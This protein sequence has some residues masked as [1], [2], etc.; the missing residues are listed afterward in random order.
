MDPAPA[1]AQSAPTES[2]W[3]E[4]PFLGLRAF[5]EADHARFFGQDQ[6]VDRLVGRVMGS[7]RFTA[8][9]GPSGSGKS[10][11]VQA[12]L[13][14]RLRLDY[15]GIVIAS[16]QPGAQ[17]YAVLEAALA[18]LPGVDS[19]AVGRQ[20]SKIS[21]GLLDAVQPILHGNS[22]RFLLV[23]DQ[24][25]E[26][27]TM[28]DQAETTRFLALLAETAGAAESNV[29]VLVTLRA[30][31]YDRPLADPRIGQLFADNVVSVVAL[32]PDQLEA[33]AT[34]PARQLDITVEPRLVG[35][36]IADVAGQPNALPL[37]Q[38]ALT[39]LFDAREGHVLDLATYE[40]IGGVRKAVARRAESLYGQL[41]PAEQETARQL[42]L[43]IATVSGD[44]VG[45]RRVPAS[46]LVSLDVDVIALKTA[47]DAFARYRLLA[48]DRDPATGS[49]TVEVAHEALLVEWHRLR[50]WID[51]YRDD[52]AKQSSFLVAVNEW[53]QS[54]RDAG[55]LLT[56][57]RL[58]DYERW[59]QST[60]LRLTA[61]EHDFITAAVA[62]RE[63]ETAAH[64][65]REHVQLKL[66]RRSRRQLLLLFG[67]VAV[68][69]GV[70]AY[71]IVNGDSGPSASIAA[72]LASRRADSALDEL[73]GRGIESSAKQFNLDSTVL[74]PP[75]T[76]IEAQI[77]ALADTGP[78][79]MFASL[80]TQG[81][82]AAIAPDYPHTDF[83]MIDDTRQPKADNVVSLAF[84][85]EQ[86]SFLVGAAAALESVTKKVGY[87]GANSLPFIES[88]RAGF[89]QGAAAA[90]PG[91][92]VVSDLIFPRRSA[93]DDG[94]G[95]QDPEIA[96]DIATKMYNDGVDVIFVAAGQSGTGVIE[97]STELST[98]SRKL[99][100]IGVDTDQFFDVNDDQRAHLLT[101][102]YKRTDLATA[103]VVA[104]KLHGKLHAPSIFTATLADG[105]VGYTNT[106]GHLRPSTIE[107]LESL[108][109][110][111]V[112]RTIVVN[113]VPA[114]EPPTDVNDTFTFDLR[115]G[116]RAPLPSAIAG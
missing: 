47:I 37:F 65:E 72:V 114:T 71:P 11:V 104:A 78:S 7:S 24:F 96:K 38:Y 18:Q 82:L 101:S 34:L 75:Y 115:T 58:A 67:V 41:Q 36:L 66:R 86:G 106:G 25:E 84:A 111:I 51:Q 40:R 87:I 49:P 50:D 109:A 56:G 113:A 12:G 43:R 27:F 29:H 63:L 74:E 39:E 44:I 108:K 52:L 73:V 64:V 5:R 69:G 76:D 116:A 17:P 14:P 15:P 31:F 61:T 92:Q 112:D 94:S 48:L 9:V 55:Y 60:H 1:R 8:L 91:V 53:E 70:I 2:R 85:H 100:A 88:F 30:D 77:R 110:Q 32:G 19:R 54:G 62:A 22:Q 4:N 97:A 26:L 99:W 79:L 81:E 13:V 105:A 33:A 42:F 107:A 10:S 16:M 93:G 98:P 57:T 103:A 23:V 83:V 35:R 3:L 90:D 95:Y 45:R 68:F 59:T 6:L 20:L 46:E 102:M 89:E 21:G 28:V 80:Q